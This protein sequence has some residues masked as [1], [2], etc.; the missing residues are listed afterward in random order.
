MSWLPTPDRTG[1]RSSSIAPKW[2]G[3]SFGTRLSLKDYPF[4]REYP[5]RGMTS[6]EYENAEDKW[7]QLTRSITKRQN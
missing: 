5:E 4:K 1:T 6:S 2:K 3:R 7:L